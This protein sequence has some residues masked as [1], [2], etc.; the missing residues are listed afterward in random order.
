MTAMPAQQ[1]VARFLHTLG[2][3]R[4]CNDAKQSLVDFLGISNFS[5]E[6]GMVPIDG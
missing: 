1:S 6:L 3:L 4:A 5:D 2:G